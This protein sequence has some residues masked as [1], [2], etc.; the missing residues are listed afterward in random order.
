MS[1]P[2]ALA[3]HGR[4]PVLADRAARPARRPAGRTLGVLVALA[5]GAMAVVVV[6]VPQ[7]PVLARTIGMA[8]AAPA[9]APVPMVTVTAVVTATASCVSAEPHDQVVM[10]LGGTAH[11]AVLDGCGR[12]PGTPVPVV[13]PA[14]GHFSGP[15]TVA[16]SGARTPTAT[17]D[18]AGQGVSPLVARLELALAVAAALGAGS[19]LVVARGNTRRPAP[20]AGTGRVPTQRR[21][22][23]GPRRTHGPHA[24]RP[25]RVRTTRSAAGASARRPATARRRR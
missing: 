2:G 10:N 15:V 3:S 9:P 5:L 11:P 14:D 1:L 17:T 23:A 8:P 13:V 6:V 7:V 21:R 25:T 12:P 20:R 18:V 16:G 24:V 19:L 4:V 22:P